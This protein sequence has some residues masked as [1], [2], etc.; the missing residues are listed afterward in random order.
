[1]TRSAGLSTGVVVAVIAL[2]SSYIQVAACEMNVREAGFID[3]RGGFYQPRPYVLCI[4]YRNNA[5]A[6]NAYADEMNHYI[7][8]RLAE[9]NLSVEIL[10][11]DKLTPQDRDAVNELNIRLAALPRTVIARKTP[12]G[13]QALS[14]ISGLPS[15]EVIGSM[16]CSRKKQK[17][18]QLLCDNRNYCI[19]LYCPGGDDR[20]NQAALGKIRAV[21]AEHTGTC[22]E[23]KIPVMTLDRK[24]RD[25][26]FFVRELGI[27]KGDPRPVVA[28]IFGKARL[29][30]PVHRGD[31]INRKILF[32]QLAFLNHNASDCGP[33]AV[34]IPAATMDLL[35]QWE[36]ALDGKILQAIAESGAIPGLDTSFWMDAAIDPDT[37]A[38]S[39]KTMDTTQG[40]AKPAGL[41]PMPDD[42]RGPAQ[43][44][45]WMLSIPAAAVLL[46]IFLAASWFFLRRKQTM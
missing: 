30:L 23:Q 19:M 17:M 45:L 27:E 42:D 20:Q 10:P 37:G 3:N 13:L 6:M 15:R 7:S 18:K 32:R 4:F 24:D 12:W 43:I 33:D 5:K 25:E 39:D 35:L 16:I 22:P 44:P 29:L 46:S 9:S 21:I 40:K 28:V 8:S 31:E 11:I 36:P 34:D 26:E 14:A 2:G 41:Q 38:V 1:M